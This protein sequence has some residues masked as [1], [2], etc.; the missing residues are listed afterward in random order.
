MLVA[1]HS[2]FDL[3]WLVSFSNF[4]VDSLYVPAYAG[5][6]MCT[7]SLFCIFLPSYFLDTFFPALL[8]NEGCHETLQIPIGP[9]A[10]EKRVPQSVQKLLN[11]AAFWI[12]THGWIKSMMTPNFARPTGDRGYHR[13]LR[14][15]G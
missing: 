11:K 8:L 1:S 9:V 7:Q 5:T 2:V 6:G 14:L 12:Y 10:E 4:Y 15:L 3:W 13:I